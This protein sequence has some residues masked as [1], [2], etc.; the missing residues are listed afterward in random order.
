MSDGFVCPQ[1][2]ESLGEP[3]TIHSREFQGYEAHGGVVEHSDE[4]CSLCVYESKLNECEMLTRAD[5][6]QM[7]DER[8]AE[9]RAKV[10]V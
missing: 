9:L 10:T 7:M 6:K 3:M 2:G 1:C 4:A 8:R 5:V